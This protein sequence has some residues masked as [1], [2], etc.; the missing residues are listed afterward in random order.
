MLQGNN[1]RR[2]PYQPNA[3]PAVPAIPDVPRRSAG[4]NGSDRRARRAAGGPTDG[5]GDRAPGRG[6]TAVAVNRTVLSE[7]IKDV[8]MQRIVEGYYEPGERV[9]ELRIA[10]EFGVSQAPVREA[11]RELEILRL[12]ES[13]PFRGARVRAVRADEIAEAYP[14]RAALEELAAKLAAERLA[15]A[16]APLKTEIDAM[17]AAAADDDL[18]AFVRHDVAF[19]RVFVDASANRTLVDVWESLHVDLRTRF[20]LIQRVGDLAEVAESHVPIMEALGAGDAGGAGRLVREHIEGFG[21]W[22]VERGA[23]PAD[24]EQP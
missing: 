4:G 15:G 2:Q 21:R 17:R 12:V 13:E 10:Q 24:R 19:H 22:F 6:A 16:S 3:G 23:Q 7:Q 9:V 8:L 1:V 18:R 20:T 14:V 5:G 11:L